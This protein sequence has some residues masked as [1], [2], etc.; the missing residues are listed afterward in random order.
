MT[1]KS[2]QMNL[3]KSIKCALNIFGISPAVKGF[4]RNIW[5]SG[6]QTGFSSEIQE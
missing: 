5:I 3:E 1:A 4:T 2:S 6:Y